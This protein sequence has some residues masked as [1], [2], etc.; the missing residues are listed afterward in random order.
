VRVA[1]RRGIVTRQNQALSQAI[2]R[3][4]EKYGDEAIQRA[5]LATTSLQHDDE[6]GAMNNMAEGR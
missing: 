6:D 3:I 4:M 5:S 1:R 2:D